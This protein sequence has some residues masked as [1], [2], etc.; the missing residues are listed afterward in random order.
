M[1]TPSFGG[2][3]TATVSTYTGTLTRPP[4]SRTFGVGRPPATDGHSPPSVTTVRSPPPSQGPGATTRIKEV[5][6]SPSSDAFLTK[7]T[8]RG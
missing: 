6:S 2:T 7:I 4:T 5:A 8:G 3:S 1:G